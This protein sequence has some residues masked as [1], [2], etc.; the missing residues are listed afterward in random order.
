MDPE[1]NGN[2]FLGRRFWHEGTPVPLRHWQLRDLVSFGRDDHE[3]FAVHGTRILWYPLQRPPDV[4][5]E[6]DCASLIARTSEHMNSQ[7]EH[8]SM[9]NASDVESASM[10]AVRDRGESGHLP[11]SSSRVVSCTVMDAGFHASC[12]A[13]WNGY[14]AAGG[15][16][17]ELDVRKL[18]SVSDNEGRQDPE[19]TPVYRSTT[20]QG[21]VNNSIH[22][23]SSSTGVPQIFVCNNDSTIRVHHLPD[24]SRAATIRLQVPAN[25][26][27]FSRQGGLLASVGD[28][29]VGHIHQE[30]E[31]G[32]TQ[33]S[34]F[35]EA[36]DSGMGC[37]WAPE[38]SCVAAG[39]Q[40]GT[41]LL[42]DHR[43]ARKIHKYTLQTACRCIKF[44]PA[45]LDLLAFSENEDY[46]H[47]VDMRRLEAMQHLDVRHPSEV[48]GSASRASIT[49]TTTHIAAAAAAETLRGSLDEAPRGVVRQEAGTLSLERMTSN[50]RP[51]DLHNRAYHAEVR[52]EAAA[53]AVAAAG[54]RS[55]QYWG[56]AP[57]EVQSSTGRWGAVMRDSISAEEEGFVSTANTA[58]TT[59]GSVTLS[60]TVGG[61][62]RRGGGGGGGG[63][64]EGRGTARPLIP[65]RLLLRDRVWGRP[66]SR[67][68]TLSVPLWADSNQ[69][70]AVPPGTST[71]TTVQA[72]TASTPAV[73]DSRAQL[74]S[75]EQIEDLSIVVPLDVESERRWLQDSLRRSPA[76]AAAAGGGGSSS[77]GRRSGVVFPGAIFRL[78]PPAGADEDDGRAAA[79]SVSEAQRLLSMD[80]DDLLPEWQGI[81]SGPGAGDS[82]GVSIGALLF[83]RSATTNSAGRSNDVTGLSWS[84]NGRRLCVGT[85]RGLF[86][87]EVDDIGRRQFGSFSFV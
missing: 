22:M 71:M 61:G 19:A 1:F 16:S 66:V 77:R 8:T 29:T 31:S 25:Y 17:G 75:W 24:M 21:S 35:C 48:F 28:S 14:L 74:M 37:C 81:N 59:G 45:P 33:L 43:A 63:D 53:S 50:R 44:S 79:G 46:V 12:M 13:Y 5:Q 2:C 55:R 70:D 76:A 40:D 42:W 20:S 85:C 30:T 9:M 4:P 56:A 38:E 65:S 68:A 78:F 80:E 36:Q 7:Y 83:P 51:G 32:Y 27:V 67:S 87:F 26:C 84:Q 62:S 60:R 58:W 6:G 10:A 34:T 15:H 47:V 73:E 86:T 64:G 39:F 72:V 18:T 49:S 57:D 23:A 52:N 82:L 11:S 3:V 69:R 54:S 41:V